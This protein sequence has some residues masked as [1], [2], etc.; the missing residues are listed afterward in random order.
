MEKTT[1]TPLAKAQKF[2]ENYQQGAPTAGESAIAWALVGLAENLGRVAT[3]LDKLA[4]K[5]EEK[6]GK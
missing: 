6:G 3:A 2:L 5:V 1:L 4:N